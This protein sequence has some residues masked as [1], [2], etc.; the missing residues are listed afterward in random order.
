MFILVHEH[1]IPAEIAHEIGNLLAF[2]QAG[3]SDQLEYLV[4]E[5]LV[6]WP[7]VVE[8]GFTDFFST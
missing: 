5:S 7:V 6:Y 3:D 8:Q 4:T 1:S 2:Q